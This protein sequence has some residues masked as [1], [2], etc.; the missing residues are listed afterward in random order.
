MSRYKFNP[1]VWILIGLGAVGLVNSAITNPVGLLTKFII[2]AAVL[3]LFILLYKRFIRKSAGRNMSAYQRAAK[4][5][6]KRQKKQQRKPRRP[7]H[8][9]V[10][11][12]RT[13]LPKSKR[14]SSL[15]ERKKEHNLT[16]I[17]GKKKK[18]NR[19]LF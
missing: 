16:V 19:A 18:K 8:L 9:K 17:D 10:V 14:K 12:S 4:Q 15:E 7:S 6:A 1:L 2:A 11:N 13:L 3:A 5:S